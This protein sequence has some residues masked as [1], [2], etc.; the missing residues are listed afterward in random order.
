[1]HFGKHF[2]LFGLLVF[3]FESFFLGLD[4]HLSRSGVLFGGSRHL[5]IFEE[6]Q[7]EASQCRMV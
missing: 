5:L 6:N 2:S 4:G 3:W 7:F 1:V